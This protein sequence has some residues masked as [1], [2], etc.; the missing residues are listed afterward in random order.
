MNRKRK[1]TPITTAETAATASAAR[2]SPA[3][4]S[5]RTAS[6]A[7]SP[8][9]TNSEPLSTNVASDQNAIACRRTSA[10]ATRGPA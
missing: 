8:T 5:S 1:R 3:L 7:W 6:C 2:A 9:S 4:V 10:L